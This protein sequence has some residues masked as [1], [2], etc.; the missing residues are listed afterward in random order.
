MRVNWSFPS[1][2]VFVLELSIS[3][4]SGPESD[5]NNSSDSAAW[6]NAWKLNPASGAGVC[7]MLKWESEARKAKNYVTVHNLKAAVPDQ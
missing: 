7:D 3:E 2:S 6:E 1:Y 5:P 4:W